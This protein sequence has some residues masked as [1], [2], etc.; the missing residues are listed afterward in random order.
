M[1]VAYPTRFVRR[2]QKGRKEVYFFEEGEISAPFLMKGC[3]P[4]LEL[5][6][7]LA[8]D[9]Q[10][11]ILRTQQSAYLNY[12]LTGEITEQAGKSHYFSPEYEFAQLFT[13]HYDEFS[14][15]FPEFARLKALSKAVLLVNFLKSI[16]DA[17]LEKIQE[18]EALCH[19]S[20]EHWTIQ[21]REVEDRVDKM[22]KTF[23]EKKKEIR[24]E[25]R[26]NL[27]QVCAEAKTK[28]AEIPNDVWARLSTIRNKVEPMVFTEFS[29]EVRTII[30]DLY[31]T[32]R[33]QCIAQTG[34]YTFY[35]NQWIFDDKFDREVRTQASRYADELTQAKWRKVHAELTEAFR[36]KV[37]HRFGG[38]AEYLSAISKYLSAPAQAEPLFY[39]LR[40]AEQEAAKRELQ[41]IFYSPHL[42]EV[43]EALG[44]KAEVLDRIAS[45]IAD[46]QA[47]P[48]RVQRDDA[49]KQLLGLEGREK[50]EFERLKISRLK[51]NHF[52]R[53]WGLKDKDP[54]LDLA[55]KCL[56]VPANIRHDREEESSHFVY[57]GVRITPQVTHAPEGSS[58][59]AK[60]MNQAF[61]GPSQVRLDQN[62]MAQSRAQGTEIGGDHGARNLQYALR[63]QAIHQTREAE[64]IGRSVGGSGPMGGAGGPGNFRTAETDARNHINLLRLQA[65]LSSEARTAMFNSSGG[66]S[67]A[68][69][70]GSVPVPVTLR[71]IAL[72]KELA[73]RPGNLSDWRKLQT[74][75]IPTSA[76]LAR[77]HFYHNPVTGDSYYGR[78][79]KT[80]F[81]HQGSWH[82]VPA[83]RTFDRESTH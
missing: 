76:G 12:M 20:H 42:R 49:V 80:V 15:Y 40:D 2:P 70:R 5:M 82:K 45:R 79:F 50:T 13:A 69:I 32:N 41:G 59:H 25:I 61:S 35:Q 37:A 65:N 27:N 63:M 1:A 44:R 26:G 57:G 19:P 56:W 14:Q 47:E 77:T 51:L 64:K 38:E 34:S 48:I 54:E 7:S 72:I 39:A 17:N 74:D 4:Q 67:D 11:K 53:A 52:I 23:Q 78:D 71:N 24:Q 28:I 43:E 66:L 10:G 31:V 73:S 22:H 6:F 68:A 83:Q 21:A 55:G 18:I 3:D 16:R 8:R 33:D 75:A 36:S 29:P 60:V 81:D 62:Y 46:R 9:E 58:A 30:D